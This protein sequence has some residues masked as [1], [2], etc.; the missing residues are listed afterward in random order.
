MAAH[1]LLRVCDKVFNEGGG[2]VLDSIQSKS[3][4]RHLV[5]EPF[6]PPE[7][8]GANVL[9]RQ[10]HIGKHADGITKVRPQTMQ[11]ITLA[12]SQIV[13]VSTLCIGIRPL[14]PLETVND[15][16]F[17]G[18][19]III[20]AGEVVLVPDEVAVCPAAA[21]VLKLGPGLDILERANLGVAV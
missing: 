20:D 6:N 15:A 10:I 21:L 12:N 17:L 16:G 1:Y 11:N 9:I 18:I 14:L 4:K 2:H 3:T 7:D 19:L 13:I 5:V 8:L